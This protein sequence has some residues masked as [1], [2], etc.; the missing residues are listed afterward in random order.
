MEQKQDEAFHILLVNLFAAAAELENKGKLMEN[1]KKLKP[2]RPL[3]LTSLSIASTLFGIATI[4][5]GWSV[6]FT[7]AGK[8]NAGSF[9]SFVLWFNFSAG[10]VYILAGIIFLR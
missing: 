6:L 9:V 7:E 3:L 4:K 10:F 2:K 1:A 5:E 8:Q